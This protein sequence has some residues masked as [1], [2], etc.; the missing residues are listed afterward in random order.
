MAGLLGSLYTGNTGLHASSIGVSVVGDN[1]ANANTTGFKTSRAH[2]EDLISEFIVGTTGSNQIGRG[3]TLQRIEKL[4]A[5]GS[6]QN[7]GVPTDLAISG[8]GFFVLNGTAEGRSQNLYTRNGAFRFDDEGYLINQSGYRVQGQNADGTGQL[9]SLQ[10]D[11]RITRKHLEPNPTGQVEIFANLR[12]DDPI[13]GPFDPNDPDATSSFRTTIVAYDSLG[14]PHEVTIFGSRTAANT[15]EMNASVDGGELVGGVAGTPQVIPLGVLTFDD[16]GALVDENVP[17]P[18]NFD[19]L[20]A[21]QG[22][23][24]FDF[25]DA[26]N[27]GGTG[28]GGSSQ[29]NRVTESIANFVSQD[30]FGT[31]ELDGIAIDDQGLILGGFTNGRT[32]V[33][34]RVQLARFE[35]PTELAVVGGNNFIE[36]ASSGS[37]LVGTAR[38]GGRG[39]IISSALELS[40][41]ELSDQFIDLIAYQRAFQANSKTIQT[42]DGL[43]QEVFQL[44]R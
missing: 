23:I 21:Q 35:D 13:T 33:L 40:T 41:V 37:P 10:E 43:L 18:I 22:Q 19:W 29:W 4:F 39:A 31:G 20:G 36:T 6:F 8:D 2:F 42:A 26:I 30:G 9:S 5:Q 34:G 7:T 3:V 32:Q 11:L 17:D 15:W 1:I 24:G 12:P 25:G 27:D 44:L 16:A 14:N 38:S 28:R